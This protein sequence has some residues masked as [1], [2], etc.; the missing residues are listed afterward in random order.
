MFLKKSVFSGLLIL[1]IAGALTAQSVRNDEFCGY[2]GKSAWLQWYQENQGAMLDDRNDDSTWL[3]VPMTVHIVGTNAAG[4]YYP[5]DQ[6]FRAICEMNE[7]YAPAFIRF[8]LQ[9]GQP[10]NYLNN[11][12]WYEHD[13]MGGAELIDENKIDDRL[14]AFVVQTAAGACGYSWRDAIVLAK[15]CSGEGN[16]TWTHEGG[17]HFSLPHTFLGWED[18]SWN[19]NEPAPTTIGDNNRKVE[20]VDGSNCAQAGDGFCDTPADF[21]SDRWTCT[22]DGKSQTVQ[23]D[24]NDVPFQSDASYF[25]SYALDNCSYQFSPQ[26]LNAMRANL[27]DEHS[28]YLQVFDPMPSLP[29][30][31]TVQLLSPLDTQEVQFNNFSLTFNTI[32]N[33]TMYM[34]ELSIN[35][36]MNPRL[37]YSLVLEDDNTSITVDVQ[38]NLPK[39]CLHYWRVRAFNEWDMCQPFN[40]GQIGVIRTRDFTAT[41]EQERH[42]GLSLQPNPLASGQT[43]SLSISTDRNEQVQL[44][45]VDLSGKRHYQATRRLAAGDHLEYLPTESLSAGVYLVQIQNEQG[46]MT[47]KLVVTQ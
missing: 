18:E 43:L 23:H 44:S 20:K 4:G 25:M 24:P 27:L 10:F 16:I 38:K 29:D 1:S 19:F 6:V 28:N 9:P 39:N 33:A 41:S 13:W 46:L 36:S 40:N 14:N 12:Y 5:E 3:Y 8:Y 2:T 47:R 7:N 31:V 30:D 26:Q 42:I 32:P 21:L 15:G 45:I 34:V 11:S 17:H 37:F 22:D 35:P